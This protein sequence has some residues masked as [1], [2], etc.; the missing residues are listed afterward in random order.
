MR[1]IKGYSFGFISFLLVC[2]LVTSVGVNA[3]VIFSADGFNYEKNNGNAVVLGYSSQSE[4]K[5]SEI[6]NIP[7]NLGGLLVT[8]IADSAFADNRMLRE[9][10]FTDYINT[11]G[12]FAFSGNS[13]LRFLNIPK[14]V[15]SI[16]Q[17]AFKDCSSLE[18][19]NFAGYKI[20]K[21]DRFTFANC[22]A[23][24]S[25]V[26]PSSVTTI[27]EYAFSN[28]TSLKSIFIS[29]NVND[30]ADNA[31]NNCPNLVIYGISGSFAETYANENS[32]QFVDYGKISKIE[33]YSAI[34][35]ARSV[36]N[37]D[38]SMYIPETLAVLQAALEEALPIY[39]NIFSTQA[40]IDSASEKLFTAYDN[41]ERYAD[42]TALEAALNNAKTILDGDT[43]VYTDES[44]AELRRAYDDGVIVYNNALTSQ[45]QEAVNSA[46]S[47]IEEA[48]KALIRNV[49]FVKGDA[50]GNGVV[51]L[52]DV[53]AAQ[54]HMAELKMLS[55][56]YF[57]AADCNEDG[58]ID[59]RDVL[60]MQKIMAELI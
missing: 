57:T 28:N 36:L 21:I 9:I 56:D 22:Y 40:E 32:I 41:L 24:E 1:K 11:I 42:K 55:G 15:T 50:D 20:V 23:L 19:V 14:N 6:L 60:Y 59:L 31:F 34:I 43:S 8:D 52:V 17:S 2:L 7:Q 13:N 33:L 25:I 26:I 39:D 16:A 29:E 53:L 47:R 10:N 35:T 49:P 58:I 54:K 44:V 45:D 5:D 51:D 3:S 38:T 46:V 27:D 37:G 30:I 18:S 4:L 48:I 12:A